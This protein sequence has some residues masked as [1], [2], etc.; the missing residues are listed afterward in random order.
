MKRT[1]G[2]T[3]EVLTTLDNSAIRS[4]DIFGRTDD[5]ERD[6]VGEDTRVLAGVIV[7]IHRR[8]IDTNVLRCDNL[9]NLHSQVRL[10]QNSKIEW[11]TYSLL[12]QEEVVLRQGVSLGDNWDKIDTS[13]EALH[14]LNIQGLQPEG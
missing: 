2:H 8:G 13:A 14:D 1:F 3:P 4:L 12:E 10:D 9:T 5:G 11:Q 7:G 6:G